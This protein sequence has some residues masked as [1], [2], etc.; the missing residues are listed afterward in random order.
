MTNWKNL[1]ETEKYRIAQVYKNKEYDKLQDIANDLGLKISTLERY[2]RS[3]KHKP[4]TIKTSDYVQ[5]PSFSSAPKLT[6]IQQYHR[7]S[8]TE[9]WL[10]YLHDRKRSSPVMSVM[11]LCDIHEP[12]SYKPA[13]DT[14]LDMVEIVQPSVIFVGSDFWD[15]YLISSFG[16]DPNV[17]SKVDSYDE[18]EAL[19]IRWNQH[20][21][22]VKM[23]SPDSMLVYLNGN[24]EN[25]IISYLLKNAVNVSKTVMRELYRII[26]CGDSVLHIGDIDH[27]RLGPLQVE[28]GVRY[29]VH[30]PKSRL[31]D[32]G[33]QI[34]LMFG[35][36][37]KTKYY[38]MRGA[39]F[40]ASAI[41]SGCLC[42]LNPHYM[43]RGQNTLSGEKW[44]H[45]TAVAT[46]DLNDRLVQFEN[47]QFHTNVHETYTFFR[48]RRLSQKNTVDDSIYI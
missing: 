4:D 3:Q 5:L 1:P 47:Q 9:R 33:G 44:E 22:S 39:D 11:H 7:D 26:R 24:H 28:H 40:S 27:V 38:Q 32:E 17:A 35:H 10:D 34:S 36:G 15:F 14:A 23:K 29:N 19:E 46:F 2:C 12:F 43:R 31:V 41:M 45:G 6:D 8:D 42:E 25:R 20:I 21:R 30:A 13:V 37:H 48:G 16:T 18:L